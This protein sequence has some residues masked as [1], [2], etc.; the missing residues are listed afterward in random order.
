MKMNKFAN[1]ELKAFT[2]IELLVVIAIIA[3]LAALLLP[4]LSK[5]KQKAQALQCLGNARQW[6]LAQQIYGGDSS[7]MIPRDGCNDNGQYACDSGATTGAGS[8]IDPYAWFNVLPPTVGDQPLS[9]YKSKEVG[10]KFWNYIPYPGNGIGKIWH[11]PTAQATASDLTAL[12]ATTS[13]GNARYGVFSYVFNLDFKLKSAIKNGVIGNC[14]KYPNMPKL[15]SIRHPAD[16]V[17]I[18]EQAFSPTTETYAGYPV[19]SSAARNGILPC[20]RWTVFTQRHNMGGDIV[21]LDG[22]SAYFK[23]NYVYGVDPNGGDNRAEKLNSD[24]WWNPNRDVHY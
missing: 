22:H 1:P 20:Q 13:A 24:I 8:V 10:T 4:A 18:F 17:V 7:D 5:A 23:Y 15:T 19:G 14:F 2:L 6:G 16:Q 3:I 9:Y 11:C 21:F 12:G